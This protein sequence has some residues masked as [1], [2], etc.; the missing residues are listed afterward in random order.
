[1][2]HIGII[3]SAGKGLRF[4][5][6]TPKQYME[7]AGMPVICHSL[8]VME[9]SFLDEIIIVTGFGDEEYVRDNFVRF[10]GISKVTEIVPGGAERFDSVRNGLDAVSFSESEDSAEDVYVYIHDAARPM[11]TLDLLNRLKEDVLKYG[12]AIAAVPAKDTIKVVDDAGNV[13]TTPKRSTL[14]NVQT[15]QAFRLKGIM[16]AYNEMGRDGNAFVT[17]DAEVMERYSSLTVHITEG[18][19]KNIKITTPE[20]IFI[21][22]KYLN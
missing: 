5:T 18:D 19:Y 15:P 16:E 1:M 20:D 21:A 17:D 14:W 12:A 13:V 10:Y 7:L 3:M 6:E 8:K 11:L 4:G 22:E 9:E 2:R